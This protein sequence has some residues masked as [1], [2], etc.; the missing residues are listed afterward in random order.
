MKVQ[1]ITSERSGQAV[2]NQFTIYNDGKRYF[3]S[4]D[5]LIA[6]WDGDK[7]TLGR[8]WDY[9]VTTMKYLWIWLREECYTMVRRLDQYSG[10]SGAARI[11]KAIEA[12]EIEYNPE[13]V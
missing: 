1:N 5:S 10:N 6:E 9:S 13:M 3:Q 7:L 4:Y 11:R 12:G 2:R 8:D